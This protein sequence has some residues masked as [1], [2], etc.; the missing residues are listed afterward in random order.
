MPSGRPVSTE[1]PGASVSTS[2]GLEEP[3]LSLWDRGGMSCNNN[4]YL[5]SSTCPSRSWPQH[6]RLRGCLYEPQWVCALH[7]LAGEPH[8]RLGGGR[9]LRQGVH[10]PR[11]LLSRPVLVSWSGHY[12]RHR[13]GG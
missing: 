10:S 1:V 8:R 6:S 12:G 9:R 3:Q 5:V 7:L 4:C 2:L 11:P 13:L